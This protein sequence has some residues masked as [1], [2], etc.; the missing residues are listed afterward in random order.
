MKHNNN[1]QGMNLFLMKEK[2]NQGAQENKD[3]LLTY[4]R[5]IS[6]NRDRLSP[7]VFENMF[8]NTE[9]NYAMNT[10]NNN[11]K[12]HNIKRSCRLEYVTQLKMPKTFLLFKAQ[13]SN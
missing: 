8:K 7:T 6:L 9:H 4:T 13:L 2:E 12:I 10:A 5:S 3:T 11:F 1:R